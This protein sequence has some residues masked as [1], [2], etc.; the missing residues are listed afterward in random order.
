[1][2]ESATLERPRDGVAVIT[3]NRPDALNAFNDEMLARMSGYADEINADDRI[4]AVVLTGE[5]R[6]FCAGRDRS[7]L[8]GSA[9]RGATARPVPEAGSSEST[10]IRHLQPV[11]IAAAHGAVVGGGLGFYMQAD[12]RLACPDAYLMDGHVKSGM[13]ASSESWYLARSLSMRQAL[14]ICALG[15]RVPALQAHRLGIVD[16]LTD[17]TELMKRAFEI[18]EEYAGIDP[19]LVRQTKRVLRYAQER[20]Y[21]E[22]MELVGHLRAIHLQNRKA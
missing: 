9:K 21:Q 13:V 15:H 3:M 17:E 4:A 5:G 22:S 14:D 18:A 20:P 11:V 1:V 2:S 16:E 8:Y 10:F 19:A 6:A 12:I 7:E